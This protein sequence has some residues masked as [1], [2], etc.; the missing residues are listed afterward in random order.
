MANPQTSTE[1]RDGAPP[2][3]G[4]SADSAL[5]DLAAR[6]YQVLD[7]HE[8][9][10]SVLA[11][12]V[13][14]GLEMVFPETTARGHSGFRSWY[15]AV[16][17]RFFDEVHTLREVTVTRVDGDRAEVRVVVNWQA[18]IWD[19]PQPRSQWLGFDAYQT[20]TVLT[21][22]RTPLI[23]R[24]VVDELRPMPGSATL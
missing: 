24:Y 17:H 12:L 16:T 23:Q 8:P 18:R 20:W 15:D 19:A 5:R 4:T 21:S 2:A 10:E 11:F 7:R 13:D 22:E 9:V 14:D 3:P 6:W 1:P